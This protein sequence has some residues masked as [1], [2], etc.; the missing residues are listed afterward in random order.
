LNRRLAAR[1]EGEFG[2][3]AS[4][5]EF[6]TRLHATKE[7]VPKD[8]IVIDATVPLARVVDEILE[9]CS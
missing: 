6:I 2:G 7:N 9:K 5:R 8:A 4:E 1:P 3:R